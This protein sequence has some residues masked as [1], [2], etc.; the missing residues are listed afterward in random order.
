MATVFLKIYV[1]DEDDGDDSDDSDDDDGDDDDAEDDD[2][3]DD[4]GWLPL[5]TP[6][7]QLHL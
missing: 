1:N 7:M 4:D 6:N 3:E 2:A 5:I